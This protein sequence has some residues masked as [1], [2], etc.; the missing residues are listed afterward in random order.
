[1]GDPQEFDPDV[2]QDPNLS[3]LA[4]YL[5]RNTSV[6]HCPG[7]KRMGVYQGSNPNMM[8]KVIPAART[9]S[10]NQAL[11]T[12]CPEFDTTRYTGWSNSK[13]A[14]APTLSVNGICLNNQKTHHR[15]SPWLTYGKSSDI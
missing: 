3:L 2:L 4:T 5:Q 11:G 6:F 12:I 8:G 14:G 7:D 15:D 10:M 1:V 9:F 13:H